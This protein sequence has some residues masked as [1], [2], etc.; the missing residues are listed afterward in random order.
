MEQL[1]KLYNLYLESGLISAEVTLEQFSDSN[2][3]QQA[4]LFDLGGQAGLFEDTSFDQFETAFAKK[5]S[6][7]NLRMYHRGLV[8]WIRPQNHYLIPAVNMTLS[9]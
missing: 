8:G 6:K 7:T 5:K 2:R 9:Q 1:E 3:E 4:G